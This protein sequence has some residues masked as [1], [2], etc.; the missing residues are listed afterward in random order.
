MHS[1][2]DRKVYHGLLTNPKY[3]YYVIS[4]V[5]FISYFNNSVTRHGQT[6]A[7]SHG[8]PGCKVIIKQTMLLTESK[9]YDKYGK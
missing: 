2:I 4:H 5:E 6:N 9:H 3:L 7:Y 8:P 1:T